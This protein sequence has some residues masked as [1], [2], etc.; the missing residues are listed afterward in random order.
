MFNSEP[1]VDFYPTLDVPSVNE[2][3]ESIRH[4]KEL[5]NSKTKGVVGVVKHGNCV[6]NIKE[7]SCD[8]Y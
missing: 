8:P 3:E 2:V 6:I 5:E 4:E 1:R 7:L